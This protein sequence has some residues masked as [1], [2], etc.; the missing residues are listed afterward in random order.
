M[1]PHWSSTSLQT[2]SLNK[3]YLRTIYLGVPGLVESVEKHLAG[4]TIFE[5]KSGMALCFWNS[6][7]KTAASAAFA[8]QASLFCFVFLL[9]SQTYFLTGLLFHLCK[10]QSYLTKQKGNGVGKIQFFLPSRIN[11][12]SVAGNRISH[13]NS[14][15]IGNIILSTRKK[16]ALKTKDKR[17]KFKPP[18]SFVY[19]K[20]RAFPVI[21]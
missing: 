13:S 6:A 17:A 21:F 1:Q 2:I 7:P 10:Y 4:A 19:K 12:I 16:P 5:R 3:K 15:C 20:L 14:L 11:D 9:F 18:S 8:A